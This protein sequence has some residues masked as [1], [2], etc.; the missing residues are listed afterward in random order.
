ML[1]ICFI[2]CLL[3][4]SLSSFVSLI[5]CNVN[6]LIILSW[7]FLIVFQNTS[8]TEIHLICT[9][10]DFC[11]ICSLWLLE[12]FSLRYTSISPFISDICLNAPVYGDVLWPPYC[13]HCLLWFYLALFFV[14]AVTPCHV[15]IYFAPGWCFP[16]DWWWLTCKKIIIIITVHIKASQVNVGFKHHCLKLHWMKFQTDR[17][18]WI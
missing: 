2:V 11:I 12:F 10:Q 9:F 7:T 17:K 8:L 18:R 1:F 5:L 15:S 6:A 3:L 14:E 16:F 13:H 4:S